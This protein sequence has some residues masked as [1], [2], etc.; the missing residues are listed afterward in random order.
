M[1]INNN[2]E[3]FIYI[4]DSLTETICDEIIEKFDSECNC[5]KKID[6]PIDMQNDSIFSNMKDIV[7]NEINKHINIYYENLNNNIFF[8]DKVHD[9]K[10]IDKFV[11]KKYKKNDCCSMYHNDYLID[12]QNKKSRILTFIFFLNTIDEG[13]EIEFFGY[14]KIKPEKGKIIIFPSEWFFP[15]S[16]KISISDDKYVIKGWIYI[17]I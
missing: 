16:E 2:M 15:Y 1:I 10:T 3:E 11:I 9:T 12:F 13:G 5:K 6:I 4:N 14:H 7:L 8:F 17:D